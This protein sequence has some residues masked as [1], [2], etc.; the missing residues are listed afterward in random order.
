MIEV[1]RKM[2]MII[3]KYNND[4]HNESNNNHS[5]YDNIH[6]DNQTPKQKQ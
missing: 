5:N 6:D 1:R 4:I 2:I 3:K